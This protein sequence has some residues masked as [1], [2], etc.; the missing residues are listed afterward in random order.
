MKRSALIFITVSIVVLGFP[1][2]FFAQSASG[3][4]VGQSC[5]ASIDL[6][7]C[8]NGQVDFHVPGGTWEGHW[9]T[10]TGDATDSWAGVCGD[11]GGCDETDYVNGDF[12]SAGTVVVGY[13]VQWTGQ[14]GQ[15]AVFY[16]GFCNDTPISGTLPSSGMP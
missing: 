4:D 2:R 1:Q 13:T 5:S 8:V 15:S 14:G 10:D 9:T 3:C 6:P 16:D 12:D 7:R 11:D